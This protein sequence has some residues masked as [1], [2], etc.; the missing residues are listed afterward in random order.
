MNLALPAST[1]IGMPAADDF[2]VRRHIGADAS[3][4]LD[5]AG[6][7]AE[8]GDDLIH[9]E[10]RSGVLG[11]LPERRRNSNGCRSGCRLCTGSTITAARSWTFSS[12][13]FSDFRRPV[14]EHDHVLD[15]RMAECRRDGD[16][17]AVAPCGRRPSPAPRRTG[18]DSRR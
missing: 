4:R 13:H 9:D 8:A 11:D 7:H 3:E 17:P 14:I 10:C 6:M 16:G 18:H 12:I 15:G 5:A 2:A 1:P